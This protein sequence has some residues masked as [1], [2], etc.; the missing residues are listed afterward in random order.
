MNRYHVPVLRFPSIIIACSLSRLALP[1]YYPVGVVA[2]C[3][4][5]EYRGQLWH[6]LFQYLLKHALEHHAPVSATLLC[7]SNSTRRQKEL[8]HDTVCFLLTFWADRRT[9]RYCSNFIKTRN[10]FHIRQPDHGTCCFSSNICHITIYWRL[11]SSILTITTLKLLKSRSLTTWTT[12][13]LT[14][15]SPF[16]YISVPLT[17]S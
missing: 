13:L 3:A 14:S 9:D 17:M 10:N 8:V 1:N 2:L 15:S 11:R 6:P 4:L 12:A 5:F 16:E 7:W